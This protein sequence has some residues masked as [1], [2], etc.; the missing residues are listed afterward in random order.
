MGIYFSPTSV[1][2]IRQNCIFTVGADVLVG[3]QSYFNEILVLLRLRRDGDIAP[4][5][6]RV[7][8]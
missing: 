6:S 7:P 2:K 1:N 5:Q 8:K 4:Y 3:P